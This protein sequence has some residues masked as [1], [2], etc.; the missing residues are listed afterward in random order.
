MSTGKLVT[1]IFLRGG[2]LFSGHVVC[3]YPPTFCPG[4]YNIRDCVLNI[5]APEEDKLDFLIWKSVFKKY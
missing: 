4:I 3:A 5:I 2:E 1:W